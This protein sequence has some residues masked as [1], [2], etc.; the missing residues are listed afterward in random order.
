MGE[1]LVRLEGDKFD[2]EELVDHFTSADWNVKRDED[3]YYYLK[4]SD[5]NDMI[6]SHEVHE[7]ALELIGIMNGAA[8]HHS[9]GGFRPVEFDGLTEIDADD[10]RHNYVFLSAVARGRSRVIGKPTVRRVNE[11]IDVTQ[12]LSEVETL[13]N[14]ADRNEK[15]ADAL[16]FCERGDWINGLT[17]FSVPGAMR[18]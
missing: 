3:G 4:S 10:R 12:V 18:V 11:T 9:G 6:D 13:A 17:P 2:L 1:W 15:V 14:L 16:R 7:R 5:F 8:S